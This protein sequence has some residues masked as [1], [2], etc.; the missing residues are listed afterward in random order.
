M[1]AEVPVYMQYTCLVRGFWLIPA[2][3]DSTASYV[4][5]QP[6]T[7]KLVLQKA[8]KTSTGCTLGGQ[9]YRLS[10]FCTTNRSTHPDLLH[11]LFPP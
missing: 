4:E 10:L 5:F 11:C 7:C 3:A 1:N 9:P 8:T 2:M 6:G